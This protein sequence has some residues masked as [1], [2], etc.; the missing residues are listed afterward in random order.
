MLDTSTNGLYRLSAALVCLDS[1]LA[2]VMVILIMVDCRSLLK[3]KLPVPVAVR[4]SLR[5]S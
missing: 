5:L 4:V 1:L 2:N 3:P